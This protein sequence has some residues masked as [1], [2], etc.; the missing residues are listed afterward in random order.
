METTDDLLVVDKPSDPRRVNGGPPPGPTKPWTESLSDQGSTVVGFAEEENLAKRNGTAPGE[1]DEIRLPQK[2]WWVIAGFVLAALVARND[3]KTDHLLMGEQLESLTARVGGVER[4]T[5]SL[6]LM[7]NSGFRDMLDLI[8]L[9]HLDLAPNQQEEARKAIDDTRGKITARAEEIKFASNDLRPYTPPLLEGAV[10]KPSETVLGAIALT[11]KDGNHD[12][13]AIPVVSMHDGLVVTCEPTPGE[14]GFFTVEV[15]ERNTGYR[16]YFSRLT[17]VDVYAGVEVKQG[18]PIGTAVAAAPICLRI[19]VIR[20]GTDQISDPRAFL[21][22]IERAAVPF[23]QRYL[24][25]F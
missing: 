16:T 2:Y 3:L 7:L 11:L 1:A 20:P 17:A 9:L 12:R 19:G 15:L 8:T 18:D 24:W 6:S 10:Y 25:P 22:P 14:K 21:P 13:E 23:W 5:R 4:Q